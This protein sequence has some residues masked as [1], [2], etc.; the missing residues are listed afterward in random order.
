[1]TS[2]VPPEI[3]I[4]EAAESDIPALG[5]MAASSFQTTRF[6]FDLNFPRDK[7]AMLYERWISESCR[8]FADYVGVAEI[9]DAPAGYVSC[10]LP[11]SGDEGRMGLLEV[12]PHARRRGVGRHL[13]AHACRWFHERNVPRILLPT[14]ARNVAIQSLCARCGLL[15][16]AFDLSYHKWFYL[17]GTRTS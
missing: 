10:H 9:G 17:P 3:A 4:R 16:G 13:L 14:Q 7:C 2:A 5:R 11:S 1:M 12:A 15:P 6:Y 8:G